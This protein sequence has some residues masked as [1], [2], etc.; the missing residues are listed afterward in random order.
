MF[1][2]LTSSSRDKQK[3]LGDKEIRKLVRETHLFIFCV[4][5]KGREKKNGNILLC[6]GMNF[7]SFRRITSSRKVNPLNT[8]KEILL[9]GKGNGMKEEKNTWSVKARRIEYK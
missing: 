6:E 7:S 2:P 9:R 3:Q 4:D 5:L 8:A 1:L